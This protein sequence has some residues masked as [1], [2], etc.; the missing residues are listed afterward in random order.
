MIK[1]KP[2]TFPLNKGIA[3]KL[4]VIANSFDLSA[5]TASVQYNLTTEEGRHLD[6]G[7]IVLTEEQYDQWGADNNFIVNIVLTKLGLVKA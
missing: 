5:V 3:T 4:Q 7:Y 6:T 2:V 1:I